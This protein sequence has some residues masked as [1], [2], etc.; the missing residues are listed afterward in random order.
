MGA[1]WNDENKV[2]Y[3]F[4]STITNI[5]KICCRKLKNIEKDQQ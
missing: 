2:N 3:N 1:P 5:K 4:S